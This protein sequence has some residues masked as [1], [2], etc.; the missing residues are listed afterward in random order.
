LMGFFISAICRTQRASHLP[1][2]GDTDASSI[3]PI[4]S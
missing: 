1:S 4:V 2:E 3:H